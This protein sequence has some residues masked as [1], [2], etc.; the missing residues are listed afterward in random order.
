MVIILVNNRSATVM[1]L[2]VALTLISVDDIAE[3]GQLIGINAIVA[4]TQQMDN[5]TTSDGFN[6][7]FFAEQVAPD[8]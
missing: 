1:A 3:V 4:G 6:L 7:L 8:V 2:M 5:G